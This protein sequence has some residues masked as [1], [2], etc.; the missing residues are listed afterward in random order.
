MAE[1]TEAASFK[2]DNVV[3]RM[4]YNKKADPLRKAEV[5]SPSSS[6]APPQSPSASSLRNK[7]LAEDQEWAKRCKRRRPALAEDGEA[8]K[9]PLAAKLKLTL[10]TQEE[11]VAKAARDKELFTIEKEKKE[12]ERELV[13]LQ[14]LKMRKDL[15]LSI[16]FNL[17]ND[18][19]T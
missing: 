14:V 5:L 15:G 6:S 3:P 7:A 18:K 4:L 19:E 13:R 1:I 12:C 9:E 10:A 17:D 2:W 16:D 11:L 8:A